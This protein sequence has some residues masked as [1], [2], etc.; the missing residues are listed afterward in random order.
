MN[1]LIYMG[2]IRENDLKRGSFKLLD[3]LSF[4]IMIHINTLSPRQTNHFSG[5]GGG[6]MGSVREN[7]GGV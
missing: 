5:G 7:N 4:V 1:R 6:T 2:D 3:V